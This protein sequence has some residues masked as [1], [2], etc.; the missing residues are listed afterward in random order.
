[1]KSM[2]PASVLRRRYSFAWTLVLKVTVPGPANNDGS[3][4]PRSAAVSPSMCHDTYSSS[5]YTF[6]RRGSLLEH[7]RLS[8]VRE[9]PVQ[10][11]ACDA[12]PIVTTLGT[13]LSRVFKT[14]SRSITPVMCTTPS[15]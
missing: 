10:S 6:S 14:F 5:K 8:D 13:H 1:M 9:N 4:G 2:R 11:L 15:R 12:L 3:Y 7:S